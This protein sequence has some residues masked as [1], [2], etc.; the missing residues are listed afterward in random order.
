MVISGEGGVVLD[1]DC[2]LAMSGCVDVTKDFASHTVRIL[3]L[4]VDFQKLLKH[5]TQ[6]HKH[7]QIYHKRYM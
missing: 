7:R 3:L 6:N 5:Q 1:K 2:N 4:H